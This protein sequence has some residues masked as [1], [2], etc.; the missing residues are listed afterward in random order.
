MPK[1]GQSVFYAQRRQKLFTPL[2]VGPLI[3]ATDQAGFAQDF[4]ML[5]ACGPVPTADFVHAN[6]PELVIKA[7]VSVKD[8]N[9]SSTIKVRQAGWLRLPDACHNARQH[10]ELGLNCGR[11]LPGMEHTRG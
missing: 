11:L 5:G 8:P 4:E 1:L 2:K 6:H 9:V 3:L 10:I 7:N